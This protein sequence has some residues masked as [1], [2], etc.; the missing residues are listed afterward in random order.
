MPPQ[1]KKYITGFMSPRKFA[2]S[3]QPRFSVT[4]QRKLHGARATNMYGVVI[5]LIVAYIGLSK[6]VL[7][8][9]NRLKVTM[10]CHPLAPK[11]FSVTAQ[12][13]P[14][15]SEMITIYKCLPQIRV[16]LAKMDMKQTNM[17]N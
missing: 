12:R 13:K 10:L 7:H 11:F 8:T 9:I 1:P 15:I 16:K 17:C 5:I 2:F 6:D 4:A 14:Q 3:S